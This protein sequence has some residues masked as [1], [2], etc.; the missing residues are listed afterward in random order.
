MFLWYPTVTHPL[1]ATAEPYVLTAAREAITRLH[2]LENPTNT[3][4]SRPSF[5]F[6]PSIPTLGN[7]AASAAQKFYQPTRLHS[8]FPP[9]R[10]P[11]SPYLVRP[12]E[13]HQPPVRFFREPRRPRLN[14]QPLVLG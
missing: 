4:R 6:D 1:R 5:A 10:H 3:L 8:R 9:R 14:F 2:K 13:W 7:E 12:I 11:V